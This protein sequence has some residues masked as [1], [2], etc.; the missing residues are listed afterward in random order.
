MDLYEMGE[1]GETAKKTADNVT[2]PV[3]MFHTERHSDS[4]FSHYW[5]QSNN[6]GVANW[7]AR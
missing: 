7:L 2:D 4:M 6:W 5:V 1:N 3:F